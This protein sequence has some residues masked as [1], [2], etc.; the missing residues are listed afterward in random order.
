MLELLILLRLISSKKALHSSSY[1]LLKVGVMGG[2]P[3]ESGGTP[4]HVFGAA[5]GGGGGIV[6]WIRLPLPFFMRVSPGPF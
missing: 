3:A 1:G 5:G 4:T 2:T 6:W